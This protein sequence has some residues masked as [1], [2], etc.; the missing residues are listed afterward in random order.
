MNEQLRKLSASEV[1]QLEK[2]A[3]ELEQEM[4]LEDFNQE[5]TKTLCEYAAFCCLAVEIG[6]ERRFLTPRAVLEECS[7]EELADYYER[8]CA[9]Y[10][11]EDA[12]A[13]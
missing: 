13:F 9:L 10:V 7:L 6:G 8:Y 2:M 11:K 1:L 5:L 12:D 3:N 4:L